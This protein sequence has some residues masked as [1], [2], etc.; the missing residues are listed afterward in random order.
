MYNIEEI[1]LLQGNTTTAQLDWK[2]MERTIPR[3]RLP[4]IEIDPVETQIWEADGGGKGPDLAIVG[5]FELSKTPKQLIR[6]I[7]E[8]LLHHTWSH[9][10]KVAGYGMVVLGFWRFSRIVLIQ[11]IDVST[12]GIQLN[13]RGFTIRQMNVMVLFGW[14]HIILYES[15]WYY[16][17]A[18]I[19]FVHP[20]LGESFL[21]QMHWKPPFMIN[22]KW[23]TRQCFNFK[24]HVSQQEM[25]QESADIQAGFEKLNTARRESHR[26]TGLGAGWFRSFL[27]FSATTAYR[28]GYR[29]HAIREWPSSRQHR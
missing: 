18:D 10:M 1:V 25:G 23:F 2:L 26:I 21:F 8:K 3:Y 24:L 4:P 9:L 13:V 19:A 14:Q 29:D 5:G 16:V 6:W 22:Y 7:F 15:T 17:V 20:G 27:K 28:V 12:K 11:M